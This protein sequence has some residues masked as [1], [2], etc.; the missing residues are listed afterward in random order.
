M[1]TSEQSHETHA[2]HKEHSDRFYWLVALVLAIVTAMEVGLFIFNEE[3]LI[4]KWIEITILL[5][6]STIKG[7]GVVAYFMHLRGDAR[8]FQFVFIVPLSLAVTFFLIFRLLFSGWTGVA[9]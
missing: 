5:I 9:G 7:I 4:A 2:T 8:I 3:G 1:T 6:L